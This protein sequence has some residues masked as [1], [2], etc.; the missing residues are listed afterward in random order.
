MHCVSGETSILLASLFLLGK[1][2]S[3]ARF[4]NFAIKTTSKKNKYES[5]D[6]K[7]DFIFLN[8]WE[9]K[10]LRN[11]AH[12]FFSSSNNLKIMI[13]CVITVKKMK[14]YFTSIYKLNYS[15]C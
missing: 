6:E 9:R 10:V 3:A 4:T 7:T 5:R 15:Y 2:M 11:L 13:I 14:T 12:I 8:G 1:C